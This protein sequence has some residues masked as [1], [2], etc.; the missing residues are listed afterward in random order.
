MSSRNE[1]Q[2]IHKLEQLDAQ[3]KGVIAEYQTLLKKQNP[4][5]YIVVTDNLKSIRAPYDSH[6]IVLSEINGDL[7]LNNKN[8]KGPL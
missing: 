5:A 4:H 8:W 3:K 1:R 2:I 7:L 6:V